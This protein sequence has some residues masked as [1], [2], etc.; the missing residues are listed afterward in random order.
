MPRLRGRPVHTYRNKVGRV[1]LEFFKPR[2]ADALRRP[3]SLTF[4]E[5]KA[6]RPSRLSKSCLLV[7]AMIAISSVPYSQ[8]SPVHQPIA[9]IGD[10]AIYEEDLDP[11]IG[12]QLLQ[13][14][15]QEYELKIAAVNKLVNRRLLAAAA[16]KNQ[17]SVEEFLERT[18]D[19][20]LPP[21]NSAELEGYYLAQKDRIKQPLPEVRP[22]LE[23][24]FIQARRQQ[25]R[26][27][28]VDQLRQKAGLVILLSR[29]RVGVT[30]DASR[31]Q[32]NPDAPVTIVEFADYQCRF[33][34]EV[35]E[36][37]KTIMTEYRGKV[38]L[39]FR[40]F[41]LRQ[42]HPQ[43]ELAAE[44]SRCAGD[45]SKFWEYHDLLFVNQARLDKAGLMDNARSAGLD[46]PRF[47]ACLA[48]GDFKP[49]I[50]N[51]LQLGTAAGVSGTPAFYIN[52]VLLSGAQPRSAFEKIIDAELAKR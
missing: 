49:F 51:D 11:L 16:E 52:G 2:A 24:D 6:M 42:V 13:L 9:K 32:G 18:V 4:G 19:Q 25:A 33:C 47:A 43:A 44:A 48:S 29:P 23:A 5:W 40:D 22:Q 3:S 26:Q 12:G 36:T 10:E 35:Q 34:K 28:Y 21:W 46:V 14:E 20:K 39:G 27:D 17:L 41:P 30:L 1:L 37:L 38:R 8:T 45:Q 7:A 15:N 50:E 31:L